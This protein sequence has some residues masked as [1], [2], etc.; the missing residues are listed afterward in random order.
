MRT[1]FLI[2][3]REFWQRLRTRGFV[4]ATLGLPLILFVSIG[5]S[6]LLSGQGEPAADEQAPVQEADVTRSG[7]VDQAQLIERIPDAIPEDSFV[8][9]PDIASAEAAL[10]REGPDAID[11]FYVIAADYRQ[12]GAVQWVSEEL[13][14]GRPETR[15]F[16]R[17]LAANLLPDLSAEAL[18]RVRSPFQSG[19]L[20]RVPIGAQEEQRGGILGM[21]TPFLVAMVIMI[22]L[23]TGGSYL[24]YSL[25]EEKSG[26]IMELLLVSLRPREL[27]AGKLL[28]LGALIL[29]QYAAW[30]VMGVAAL[31]IT[32]GDLSVVTATVNLQASELAAIALY[33]LGGYW[34]YAGLMA[35]LG[36]L[37]PDLESSRVWTFLISL[38]LLIPIYLWL[39]ITSA[40]QGGLAVALSLIPFSAPLAMIMRMTSTTVPTWQLVTSVLLLFVTAA[41]IVWLTARLFRA[42]T[43][44][45]GES[46]SG[47]RLWQAL[48]EA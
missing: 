12:T 18:D 46:F 24:L 20:T 45:S 1:I 30:A 15:L 47:A 2:A 26:R 22:P 6:M 9:F 19:Q 34:L 42:Q 14:V 48:K 31:V 13:P 33:G 32:G 17:L 39:A 28:G 21:T 27:L 10:T 38:P 44:L 25:T 8:S 41:G 11:A 5:G 3:W 29:V 23:F 36:A 16:E 43:L 35:G 7:F 37:S 40:P 4:L